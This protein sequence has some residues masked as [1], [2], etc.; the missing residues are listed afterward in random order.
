VDLG[1]AQARAID[2]MDHLLN[3]LE[4]SALAH[5]RTA[6][7]YEDRMQHA[8]TGPRE[9][10]AQ[11][12]VSHREGALADRRRAKDLQ[13]VLDSLLVNHEMAHSPI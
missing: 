12:A 13:R 5:D 2:A 11:K 7:C 6:R 3:A 8:E 10:F 9:G 1:V 4:A